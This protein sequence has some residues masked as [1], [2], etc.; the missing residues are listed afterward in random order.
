VSNSYQ[1]KQIKVGAFFFL[2]FSYLI[3]DSISKQA[4][5]VDPAWE[6]EKIETALSENG[7]ELTKI[8]L[9][10]SHFDHVNLVA[11]L[12]KRYHPQVY[13]SAAEIEYYNYNCDNLNPVRHL[14]AIQLG[15]T[16]IN[17]LLTP[18]HTAGGTC[19]LL[20]DDLFTG[21]TIF[22]EGC[23]LCDSTGGSPEQMYHSIQMIKKLV[24][25]ETRIYPAHSYGKQPGY[26]LRYLFDYNLYFH[27]V[28]IEKFVQ[29]R[30]RP[31][32]KG[33]F[34]FK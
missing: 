13:M 25:P 4:A 10:H 18:G 24:H 22:T 6:L 30:M 5:V 15:R 21:D 29:F 9:T 16:Q 23:G 26:P 28:T 19:Y 7:A 11:P 8:L 32:Q 34:D 1:I 17:C 31:N 27:F 2:N 12:Q 14:E 33:L 3:I 20:K